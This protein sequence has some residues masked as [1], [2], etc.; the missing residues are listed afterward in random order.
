MCTHMWD[1]AVSLHNAEPCGFSTFFC[2]AV[3][4]HVTARDVSVKR[5]WNSYIMQH[6]Y[7]L[8]SFAKTSIPIHSE[9]S[10]SR[11]K[12]VMLPFSKVSFDVL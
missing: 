4:T 10:A 3:V 2:V 12:E 9:M 5:R 7:K 8:S 6:L 11:L 1:I